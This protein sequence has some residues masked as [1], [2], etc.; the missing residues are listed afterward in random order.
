MTESE[1]EADS[2]VHGEETKRAGNLIVVMVVR[3]S[4][5]CKT[6]EAKKQEPLTIQDKLQER[7]KETKTPD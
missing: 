7:Q 5:L 1:F 4:R 6:V 3:F 2:I